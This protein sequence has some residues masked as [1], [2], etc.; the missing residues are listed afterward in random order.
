MPVTRADRSGGR[1]RAATLARRGAGLW[2]SNLA[3][4]AVGFVVPLALAR[5]AALEDYG[6]FGFASAVIATCSIFTAPG[7]ATA[8]TQGAARRQH[9]TLGIAI[10]SR[11]RASIIAMVVTAATGAWFMAFADRTTG[12][13]LLAATPLIIPAYALDLATSFLNGQRRYRAMVITLL[14]AAAAPA[15]AVVLALLAGAPVVVVTVSYFAALGLV[16]VIALSTVQRAFVENRTVDPEMI[17]YG[18]RLSWISSL[19]AVQF[20]F[21]RLVIGVTLGFA[22]VA[23]YSVAKIFQQGLK[24][25]WTAVNQQLFPALAAHDRQGASTLNRRT[26]VPIWIAFTLLAG[27]GALAAPLL[28]PLVFGTPYEASVTPARILLLAV[29]LGIP[30]A[31]F[32]MLFRAVADER[33]LYIQRITFA[34]AEVSCTGI[35][36]WLHGVTGASIGMVVAYTLNSAVGWVLA[37]AR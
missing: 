19:G 8:V 5:L 31:Q 37:R 17:R 34:V 4:M 30:G 11:V 2:A 12:V 27:L 33:K 15:L 22:E 6:R 13:L 16:N 10:A 21:D 7:L 3:V 14:S 23:I 35:G 18:R 1:S 26:L 20:Y 25:T 36:A 29:A 9:G 28:V 24:A 32:E